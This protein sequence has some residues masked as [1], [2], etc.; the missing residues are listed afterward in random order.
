RREERKLKAIQYAGEAGC[1]PT[2]S[3]ALGEQFGAVVSAIQQEI[4]SLTAAHSEATRTAQE[5]ARPSEAE[6]VIARQIEQLD[7]ELREHERLREQSASAASALNLACARIRA[8]EES[9]SR[10]KARLE[11]LPAAEFDAD[12]LAEIEVEISRL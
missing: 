2:C 7:A 11:A 9:L 8:T 1:C 12:L 4:A 3:R 5:T 6:A 10:L